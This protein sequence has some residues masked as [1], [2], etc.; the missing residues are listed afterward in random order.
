MEISL[1]IY[2]SSKGDAAAYYKENINVSSFA[3]L[4]NNILSAHERAQRHGVL[5]ISEKYKGEWVPIDDDEV[6]LETSLVILNGDQEVHL[7]SCRAAE[8]QI[9]S[10]T[11]PGEYEYESSFGKLDKDP[12]MCEVSDYFDF[13]LDKIN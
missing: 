1:T 7:G 5:K 10:W 12:D 3:E 13:Y 9:L 8:N 11:P 4:E 6:M 2:N